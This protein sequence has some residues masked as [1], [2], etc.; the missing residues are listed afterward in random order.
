MWERW[1]GAI[2]RWNYERKAKARLAKAKE[3]MEVFV[4]AQRSL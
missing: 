3:R 2:W 1:T 4:E